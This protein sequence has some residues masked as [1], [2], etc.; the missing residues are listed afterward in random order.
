MKRILNKNLQAATKLLG[1]FYYITIVKVVQKCVIFFLSIYC[2][3]NK[4]K[5]KQKK[6]SFYKRCYKPF[7]NRDNT[8]DV[9]KQK[10]ITN[11]Y[12]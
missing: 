11:L 4:D 10:N 9:T 12:A 2:G 8:T 5:P 3:Q 7:K 1:C 6:Y